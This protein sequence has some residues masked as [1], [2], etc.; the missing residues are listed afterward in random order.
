VSVSVF[1]YL[2]ALILAIVAAFPAA[3]DW[4]LLHIS[5]VLIALVLVLQSGLIRP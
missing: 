2:L 3:R 4:F 1:C 5:V